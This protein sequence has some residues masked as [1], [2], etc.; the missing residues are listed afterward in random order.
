MAT[1]SR[2]DFEQIASA[3]HKDV[4]DVCRY[5]RQFEAAAMWYRLDLARPKKQTP[6]VL[7]RRMML[8]VNTARRLLRHL[9]VEDASQASDGPGIT[10]LQVLGPT[11]DGTEDAV[12]RATARV[13]RL[14]EILEAVDAVRELERRASLAAEDV[15]QIGEL[16]VPE[17]HRGDAAVNDWVA[18]LMSIYQK[19]TGRDPGISVVASGRRNRGKATGP[20]IR[21]LQ[22]AGKPIGINLTPDSF[23]GRIKDIRTGG[24]RRKK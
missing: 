6:S 14:V 16:V 12:V 23:A 4:T 8:L 15:V 11:A 18:G 9:E 2:A 1:Y 13:G 24:R 10:I 5:E 20:L 19:I 7:R 22:A 3:L 17:G 21:F